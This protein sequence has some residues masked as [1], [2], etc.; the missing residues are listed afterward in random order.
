MGCAE[1]MLSGQLEGFQVGVGFKERDER[2]F[3]RW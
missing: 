1:I 2:M 3:L